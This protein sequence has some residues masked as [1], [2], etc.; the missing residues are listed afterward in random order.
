MSGSQTGIVSSSDEAPPQYIDRPLPA[1]WIYKCDPI[2]GTRFYADTTSVPHRSTYVHPLDDPIYIASLT[3]TPTIPDVNAAGRARSRPSSDPA[4]P[5]KAVIAKT[6]DSLSRT[7]NQLSQTR[8]RPASKTTSEFVNENKPKK[9]LSEKIMD[10]LTGMS[11]EQ[12]R[13]LEMKKED[14]EFRKRV[15]QQRQDDFIKQKKVERKD[16]E[17]AQR[18]MDNLYYHNNLCRHPHSKQ[19]AFNA[20]Q[21]ANFAAMVSANNTGSASCTCPAHGRDSH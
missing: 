19:A 2:H 13:Q 9:G 16:R 11:R 12:R 15:A 6:S 1:G 10:G 20:M 21:A 14:L 18:M 3:N 8:F 5:R 17:R 7:G 4:V